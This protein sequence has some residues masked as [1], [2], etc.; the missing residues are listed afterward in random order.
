MI[1]N[2]IGSLLSTV[3]CIMTRVVNEKI[4][5]NTERE[6]KIYLN[7]LDVFQKYMNTSQYNRKDGTKNIYW[8]RK[9]N[10]LSLLNI[11][12]TMRRYGPLINLWEGSNQGE[13]Y[14]RHAKPKITYIN[15]KIGK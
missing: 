15:Q 7:N 11:P 13:G 4:V 10:F 2:F 12:D 8:V 6:I 9:Y 14:L 1:D 5:I 3:S